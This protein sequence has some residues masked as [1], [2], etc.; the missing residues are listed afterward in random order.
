MPRDDS[1]HEKTQYDPN[2]IYGESY[3]D[4]LGHYINLRLKI[5]Q[6]WDGQIHGILATHKEYNSISHFF[7]DAIYHKLHYLWDHEEEITP[8]IRQFRREITNQAH[9]GLTQG[10]S[11]QFARTV[12]NLSEVGHAAIRNRH[13]GQLRRLLDQLTESLEDY[14]E[15]YDGQL[16]TEIDHWEKAL[17]YETRT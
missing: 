4:E 8:A 10:Q 7:R 13:L 3:K 12:A 9:L 1:K 16:Q 5:P 11:D 6:S 17:K 15:P 14:E 2:E